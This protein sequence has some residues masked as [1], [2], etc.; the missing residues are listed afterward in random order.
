MLKDTDIFQDLLM[1]GRALPKHGI[2]DTCFHASLAAGHG[3]S[4]W[5]FFLR[6]IQSNLHVPA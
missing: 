5:T 3:A 2:V 6:N 1:Q 4:T